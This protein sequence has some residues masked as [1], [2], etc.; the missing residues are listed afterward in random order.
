MD[1]TSIPEPVKPYFHYKDDLSV[2]NGM[3]FLWRISSDYHNLEETCSND[4]TLHILV[5]K[6]V[7]IEP[8][9]VCIGQEL[10]WKDFISKS[11]I[12]NST[13]KNNRG[14]RDVRP[15]ENGD[16]VRITQGESL[17]RKIKY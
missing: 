1:Q 11:E 9:S 3:L 8:E 2:E 13:T 15:L 5:W 12:W 6:D 14:A 7:D 10:M 17:G 16:V 4:Y